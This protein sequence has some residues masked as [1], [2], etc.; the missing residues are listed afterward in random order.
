MR[1]SSDERRRRLAVPL[2]LAVGAVAHFLAIASGRSALLPPDFARVSHY[3]HIGV[4]LLLPALGTGAAALVDEARRFGSEIVSGTVTAVV[5]AVCWIGLPGN[6]NEFTDNSLNRAVARGYP[7]LVPYLA[8]AVQGRTDLPDDGRIADALAFDISPGWLRDAVREGRVEPRPIDTDHAQT[9]VDL[10]LSI[11]QQDGEADRASCSA[12]LAPRRLELTR[13]SQVGIRGG[14]VNVA[15]L[16]DDRPVSS[17]Q[18][19]PTLGRSFVA[20]RDIVVELSSFVAADPAQV[21]D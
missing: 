2:G 9:R 15:V 12:L 20:T 10:A 5:V 11:L 18:L 13:G 1:W 19:I 4:A 14:I 6:V 8:F 7:D 17:T 3:M 21:C 16:V